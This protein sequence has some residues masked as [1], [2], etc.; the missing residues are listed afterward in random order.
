MYIKPISSTTLT[1]TNHP[2]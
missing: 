2:P 1:S